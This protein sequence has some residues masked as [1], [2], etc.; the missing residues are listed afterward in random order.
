M[1]LDLDKDYVGEVVAGRYRIDGVLGAGGMGVV[2]E[3]HDLNVETKVALKV[4]LP[5]LS[6]DEEI[7]KRF[8]R[9]SFI[10][11]KLKHPNTVRMTDLGTLDDGRPFFVSELLEG[12]TLDSRMHQTDFRLLR[13][14]T[15]AQQVC[16]ALSEAHNLGIVHRDLKPAN[17]FMQRVDFGNEVA[18]VLDFGIAKLVGDTL[19][20]LTGRGQIMG[21]A[22][23]MAPEQALGETVDER[24]DLYS[25]GIVLYQCVSGRLPFPARP[26]AAALRAHVEDVPPSLH[27]SALRF[28][29]PDDL[30]EMIHQLLEKDKQDR[31]PSAAELRRCLR[32]VEA[33]FL[34]DAPDDEAE[35]V[36]GQFAKAS[37]PDTVE[38]SSARPSAPPTRWFRFDTGRIHT[39]Y[40]GFRKRTSLPLLLL[41]F[42]SAAVLSFVLLEAFLGS[43]QSEPLPFLSFN[44]VQVTI[45]GDSCTPP[46]L[47]AQLDGAHVDEAQSVPSPQGRY[48]LLTFD[49][50][51]GERTLILNAEDGWERT[52]PLSIEEQEPARVEISY[53]CP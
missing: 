7:A 42:A 14:L 11:R 32:L 23:Y 19:N 10:A 44:Q 30:K 28:P 15:M 43:A 25:F 5:E 2:Y 50:P 51:T 41:G 12:S 22:A 8:A 40:T 17:I 53:E 20:Q 13:V 45:R 6:L 52:I 34:L 9:E 26:I 33:Q 35:T 4:L 18:R 36:S 31:M 29:V 49:A 21:T 1:G 39:L 3:A 27:E 48:R 46:T 47:K 37:V 16:G 24:T 38:E